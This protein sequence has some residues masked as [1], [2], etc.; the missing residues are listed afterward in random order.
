AVEETEQPELVPDS[1]PTC[2]PQLTF[3]LMLRPWEKQKSRS[4]HHLPPMSHPEE[5][6]PLRFSSLPILSSNTIKWGGTNWDPASA[7]I[8]MQ[9]KNMGIQTAE[10]EPQ[11][12]GTDGYMR[13]SRG[14]GRHLE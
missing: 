6:I 9:E 14:Y 10:H 1:P 3:Q 7:Y 2:C 5:E 8:I 4:A 11:E 12:K 13:E